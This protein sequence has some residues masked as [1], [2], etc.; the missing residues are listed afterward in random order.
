M[1]MTQE[2]INNNNRKG[3]DMTYYTMTSEEN[4]KWYSDDQHT[5]DR[6]HAAICARVADGAEIYDTDGVVVDVVNQ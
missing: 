5:H 1:Q 3:H 6:V 2:H 4:E